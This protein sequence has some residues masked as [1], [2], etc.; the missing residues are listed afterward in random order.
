MLSLSNLS[1]GAVAIFDDPQPELE[2]FPEIWNAMQNGVR[3][4]K[5]NFVI[6]SR[7]IIWATKCEPAPVIT[8]D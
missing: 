6:E 2:K 3:A 1:N 4:R 8:F 5:T 7:I